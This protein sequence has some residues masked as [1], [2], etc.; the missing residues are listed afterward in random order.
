MSLACFNPCWLE[1]ISTD[2][3]GNLSKANY[4]N[5]LVNKSLSPGHWLRIF[6]FM[7]FIWFYFS[8]FPIL[9]LGNRAN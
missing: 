5:V 4:Q 7:S 2:G 6:Q 8:H 3:D 1:F 9:F